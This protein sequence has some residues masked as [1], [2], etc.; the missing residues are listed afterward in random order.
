MNNL[1]PDSIV[2]LRNLFGLMNHSRRQL[3]PI[4]SDIADSIDKGFF[5]DAD[6][7]EVHQLLTQILEVQQQLSTVEQLKKSAATKKLESIDKAISLLEQNSKR[8][9][10]NCTLEK[11]ETLVVDSEDPAIIAAVRKVKLQV[12]HIRVKSAK[13]DSEQFASLAERF[14]LLAEMIENAENFSSRD[15][16][17]IYENFPDNPLIVMA[18]TSRFVRFEKI[19]ESETAPP[20]P[21][22][23]KTATALV[24]SN[25]KLSSLMKKFDKVKP[26]LSLVL[27]EPENF[28]IQKS[29]AKKQLSIKSFNNK[30]RQLFDSVDPQPI[31]KI[32]IKT[33]IF[34]TEDPKE[35]IVHGKITKKIVALIPRLMEKL[36]DWGMADKITWRERPFYYVNDFGLEICRKF[37]DTAAQ[38]AAN[39]YFENVIHS[40]QFA[41]MFI[42][43]PRIKGKNHFNLINHP[44]VP[45]AHTNFNGGV[46]WFFSLILLGKDWTLEV[47]KFKILIEEQLDSVKAIFLFAFKADDF[48]W[49]VFF[50][51]T[52]I[53][54][55]PLYIFTFDGLFDRNKNE[56]DFDSWINNLEPPQPPKTSPPETPPAPAPKN[57]TP[58]P[59]EPT[60]FDNDTTET[61]AEKVEEKV[62]QPVTIEVEVEY[63]EIEKVEENLGNIPAGEK[64]SEENLVTADLLNIA[65]NLFKDGKIARGMLALHALNDFF[66]NT[67]D[68][69]WADILTKEIGFIL[70]DPIALQDFDTFTFWTAGAEIPKTNIGSTFD[71]LNLAA[72]IKNF[73]EPSNPLSYQLQKI[74]KQ[75]NDDKSNTALKNCPAAKT[76]IKL[77]YDFT[78]KTRRAFADSIGVAENNF[79][80]KFSAAR[81]QL[82]N[83]EA[84]T[85]LFLHSE[86]NHPHMRD[87]AHQLFKINGLARK[88]LDV[89]KFSDEEIL[90]FCQQFATLKLREVINNTNAKFNEK[91][92]E[93]KR[94]G[95]FIDDVWSK[96]EDK[97]ARRENEP[98]KKEKRKKVIGLIRQILNALFNYLCAKKNLKSS[99][100][101]TY[102]AA[103]ALKALPLVDDLQ[104]QIANIEK[105]GNLGIYVFRAFVENL[106]KRL[107]GEFPTFNYDECLLGANYIELENNFPVTNSF[108]VADFSFK[109]RFLEFESDIREKTFEENLRCACETAVK[110]YDGGILADIAN[111]FK[112][113]FGEDELKK[114]ISGIERQVEKQI[115]RIYNDFLNDLELARNYSRITDQEKIDFYINA[116]VAAKK[117]FTATKNAGLFQR[118]INA[119]N[120]SINKAST[121]Q[122]DSLN[123]RLAALEENLEKNLAEGETLETRYPILAQV[124][125]QIDLMNL[126]VAEDYMN[127]IETEGG[128]LLTELDVTD[129]NL[130]T[131]EDFI[132]EYE[133]LFNA[134]S[135]AGSSVEV[136]YKQREHIYRGRTNRETK[137]ALE[138]VRA[139]KEINSGQNPAI[140]AAIITILEH[141]GYGGAKITVRNAN[142]TNQKSYTVSFSEQVKIRDSYPHPFAVFG[143]E[144]F[145]KGLEIIY[146]NTNRNFDNIAQVLSTMTT[147]R[148]TIVLFNNSMTLPQRRNLAKTMKLNANLKNIIVM[149]K[150]LALYLT[151]FDDAQRGKKMLQAALP[152]ARVQ[153]YAQGGVIAPEMFIGRSE[154]LDQIRDM[155][156]P[157]LVY[158]GRQLGKSALLRQVKS[159]ENNP[160]Q[161]NYAFFI[162][163]KNLDS[164]QTLQRIVY[165]LKTANLIKNEIS[166]WAEFSSEMHKLFNGQLQGVFKPKKLL[167]LL[168]ESDAFLSSKDYET[169]INTLRELFETFSGRFKFV[170]AGLHKVIRL[171]RNS[172]FANLNHISVLPFK[173]ADAMELLVKPMSYLGFKVSSDSLLSAIFSRANYYPGLIQ[174]YCKMLV[175]AVG[176]NYNNKNFDVTKNPPYTL[177]DDYLK[178]MLGNKD[179][180]DEINK[181]FQITLELDDDNYYEILAFAVAYRYYENNRPVGV[182]INEIKNTC[183]EWNVDKITKLSDAE[184]LSLLDE[185]VALNLLRKTDNK[186]EFNRYA[187]WHM[188]GT[189][190][191]VIDKL[192][193]YGLKA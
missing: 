17:K 192:Y 171:E 132:A 186:F 92:F 49:L 53:K 113:K 183:L 3:R 100:N 147:S 40:L 87:L 28:T 37:T 63:K 27:P 50:D 120:E 19:E 88:Y 185:M 116:I 69:I 67:D 84:I 9:E 153:P 58:P 126:T 175:D 2:K 110:N 64:T 79:E 20:P 129:S 122:K 104:K 131:L 191:D 33:R 172:S 180:Q 31:F 160:A 72:T 86:V 173:P 124:R 164:E 112:N 14:I 154:E 128:N 47:A 152:F 16:L 56:V 95:D 136:A 97:I 102:A 158:G 57:P 94:I 151:R 68:E 44:T 163:L 61:P 45:A 81:V 107:K 78:D 36:F 103:P 143:T 55:I 140:E 119:C 66:A 148:G 146:L 99:D 77:F 181:K 73:F 105:R 170:L 76:L 38:V 174:Y 48:K 190:N 34:F 114:K 22:P 188:M 187:F 149:D 96:P 60:L 125:R 169:A 32:L 117:H 29:S 6:S 15:Y 10:I 106:S 24:P 177:N 101:A 8:D 25:Q 150:V 165:E 5:I 52:K 7:E 93:E 80:D 74:W 168:D 157:V 138:F 111:T 134:I 51:S 115:E 54:K 182:E 193:S 135:N 133:I 18:L 189:E 176:S 42:A 108:G 30:I 178:N 59:T 123:N 70:D 65:T 71:F 162:D 91:D 142:E 118:F 137:N 121:P 35:I 166:T 23:E 89:E 75:L 12:E 141:L 11:L 83:V 46:I 156:G 161:L 167:L 85:D 82:K 41:I 26:D 155:K 145:T 159:L 39:D 144:I 4:L 127:R 62:E 130:T 21:P 179:F 43:E 139:W 13:M 90:N 184:L 109:N 98:I 1:T